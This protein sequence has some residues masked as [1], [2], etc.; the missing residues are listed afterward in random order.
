[1]AILR[2]HR[3]AVKQHHEDFTMQA[4][5]LHRGHG[6]AGLERI[7]TQRPTLQHPDDVLVRVRAVALNQRDLWL[8]ESADAQ[9][10]GEA[11]TP[12]SDGMGEVVAIGAA[13]TRLKVGDRVAASFY[14]RWVDGPPTPEKTTGALGGRGPGMLAEF[15][16]LPEAAWFHVPASLD[17]AQA[18]TLPCAGVAAWNALFEAGAAKAG[19]T[20]LLI[21]TG[22][23][24]TWA[25]QLAHAAGLYAIVL[26]SS[27]AK[28]Q[29]AR[30]LGADATLNRLATPD[31]AP[32]VRAL[33]GGRG[34]DL[35]VD[36]GGRD[37]LARSLAALRPGGTVA[38]VGGL[39]GWR[40]E[41]DADA[42]VDGALR[43]QG[44]LVGSRTMAQGLVRF[45]EHTGIQPVID[46]RY[47]FTQARE[48]YDHLARGTH[49]GKVVIEIHPPA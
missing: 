40:G 4:Y 48:A 12:C 13:V 8:A 18:A 15:V 42:L 9:A 30:A 36:T 31:W 2:N 1:L 39:S 23:V 24:S 29:G 44:V 20:V 37:T 14:P 22:G 27:D 49:V 45:A 16:C 17:D 46:R 43:L 33:A 3:L 28:L 35:V 7:D 21:G 11:R 34:V 32:A 6:P 5:R 41:I 25:L 19:D 47:P 26:S 38:V 10:E